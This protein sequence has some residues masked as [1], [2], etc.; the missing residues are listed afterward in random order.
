M[1]YNKHVTELRDVCLKKKIIKNCFIFFFGKEVDDFRWFDDSITN[2]ARYFRYL[3]W[4]KQIKSR[5][6]LSACG[7][8]IFCVG[9]SFKREILPE[10]AK[11]RKNEELIN[12][13]KF[14]FKV[15]VYYWRYL[16][17]PSLFINV[18]WAN[19]FLEQGK[20]THTHT[21]YHQKRTTIKDLKKIY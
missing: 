18:W 5:S 4:I 11:E 9:Y 10:P 13:M 14:W 20:Y 21:R 1:K 15:T 12:I 19:V 7:Q 3:T 2:H 17:L 16:R 8:V 6:L